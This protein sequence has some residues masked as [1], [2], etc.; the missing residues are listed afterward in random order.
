MGGGEGE[1]GGEKGEM[2]GNDCV[3]CVGVN[4][5]SDVYGEKAAGIRGQS[6]REGVIWV[7]SLAHYGLSH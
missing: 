5:G 6:E 2:E 7:L 3:W 4:E 1:R